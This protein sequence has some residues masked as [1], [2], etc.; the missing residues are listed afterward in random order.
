LRRRKRRTEHG[1]LVI[2]EHL[3]VRHLADMI[4]PDDVETPSLYVLFRRHWALRETWARENGL[5]CWHDVYKLGLYRR[6]GER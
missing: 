6:S 3:R 2:P 5:S 4:R 1:E